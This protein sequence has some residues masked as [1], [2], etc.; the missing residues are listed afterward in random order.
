MACGLTVTD[1]SWERVTVTIHLVLDCEGSPAPQTLAWWL[2]DQERTLPVHPSSDGQD[3]YRV[4]INITNFSERN[5]LPD[6]SWL[7][8]VALEDGSRLLARWEPER[9][10]DLDIYTRSFLFAGNTG[11]HTVVFGITED[12]EHPSFAMR[13]YRFRRTGA[14]KKKTGDVP[15][16]AR[17]VA[18][19]TRDAV[20][21]AKRR[22]KV[23]NEIYQAVRRADRVQR[24]VKALRDGGPAPKR[25]LFASEMRPAIE[26]N[27]LQIRDRMVERGLDEQFEFR[28]SFR[29][30][31]TA[32]AVGFVGLIEEMA[33][34]DLILVDDYFAVLE[35]LDM[36]PATRVIQVWHAGSGF[37]SV[38]YS[39]F[40]KFGSPGLLSA[41]RK[42]TYAITGAEALK[43]VYAEVFGIEEDA[44]VPTGLPRIDAFLDPSRQAAM[45]EH[46]LEAY[47]IL[48]GKRVIMFAPTF[49]GRGVRDAHYDYSRIDFDAL[50]DLCGDDTVVAFRMH[51]FVREPVPIRPE[52]ADRFVDVGGYPNGN[53]LLLVTDIL[54]TDYS[55]IVY[56]YSLLRRPMVFYAYDMETYSAVRGFHRPYADTA[57]G[58]VC[59]TFECLLESI[60]N[61]DFEIEK[62]DRFRKENFDHIDTNSADRVIDWLILGDPPVGVGTGRVAEGANQ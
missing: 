1:V 5:F 16:S 11:V 33:R 17:D 26:G 24:K 59:Q 54:V 8:E 45:R 42:Y 4:S 15:H 52:H 50:Y 29:T 60:R 14:K 3:R 43:H 19:A 44:V 30:P 55:S 46:L 58:K 56:E 53:D 18:L 28:Y 9:L 21:P 48:R 31:S 38:G 61:E 27:L 35:F 57:P 41:H 12:D 40:G 34:A 51:H 39:R 13:S 6:G 23:A 32:T 7:I 10:A 49:R 22:R 36:D 47:P 62:V 20:L 2:R 37:K 25:I